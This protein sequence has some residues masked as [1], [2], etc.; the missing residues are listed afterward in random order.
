MP[1]WWCGTS[2][3]YS[4]NWYVQIPA[5]VY[6]P[7]HQNGWNANFADGHA[8][9]VGEGSLSQGDFGVTPDDNVEV[10]CHTAVF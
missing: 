2:P 6:P 4:I 7:V 1:G 10:G 9:F 5:V 8:N 3:S